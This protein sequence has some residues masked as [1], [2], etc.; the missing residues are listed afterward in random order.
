MVEPEKPRGNQKGT[1]KET[2]APRALP[3]AAFSTGKEQEARSHEQV[4]E[5]EKALYSRLNIEGL[6][7]KVLLRPGAPFKTSTL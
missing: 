6:L 3:A 7:S 1:P 2:N 4:V 5:D